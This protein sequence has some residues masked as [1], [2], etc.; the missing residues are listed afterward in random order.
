MA[1]IFS[2]AMV[3]AC[4]SLHSSPGPAAA[5]SPGNCAATAP[6]ALSSGTP[7]PQAYSSD[8]KTLATYRHSRY[9]MTCAPLTACHGEALLTAFLAAS[10]AR[11]S[12]WPAAVPASTASAPASGESSR[13]WFARWSPSGCEWRTAQRSLL[14]DSEQFSATWPRSGSMRGGMCFPLPTAAPRIFV[15]AFGSSP[16]GERWPTPTATL[17]K[18]GGRVT[19][20]KGREGG[21]L[22]EAVS[23]RM[24]PTPTASEADRGRTTVTG[25]RSPGRTTSLTGQVNQ[26]M[27]PTP[28]ASLGDPRRGAPS[29]ETA[30]K[31]YRQGKRNLDDAV[32][33][34]PTPAARD[35][36]H[37]NAKSY[38]ERGGGKKGEQLPNSVGGPLNPH[39]VEW[40]MGW[41]LDWTAAAEPTESGASAT[42]RYREWLQQHGCFWRMN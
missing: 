3:E 13:A 25:G 5:S 7:T 26:Q 11:T 41:P 38:E 16:D 29:A 4:A 24:W 6:C 19:P 21:T 15:S 36:R 9:G 32:A 30:A 27:W 1:W 31:R 34:W 40:L 8:S 35:Y 39:F 14:G 17:G 2:A 28:S 37:P 20:R 42:D 33:M 22:V 12:A 23:S 10:R 18:N